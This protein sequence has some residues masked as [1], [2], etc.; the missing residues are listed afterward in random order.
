M[1]YGA[2]NAGENFTYIPYQIESV[3]GKGGFGTVYA[4]VRTSDGLKVAIKEVPVSKV[5]DWSVLGGRRVP[6]ELRLLYFCQSVPGVV[7]LVDYYHKGDSFLYIMERPTNSR[8]LFDYIS[9]QKLL[10]EDMARDLFKQVVD[11]V[12]RCY[13]RGV[14]HR[15]IKDENLI[16][17]MDTGKLEL[18][19]F[20]S[21]AFVKSA[22][23][24]EYDGRKHA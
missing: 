16:V 4:G 15:D 9:Q 17:D 20:G 3:L 7:R 22:P 12:V 18:I 1:S 5:L 19:D 8:D 24:H 23:F 6:L 11:T 13:E 10:G 14:V 21:G 2:F